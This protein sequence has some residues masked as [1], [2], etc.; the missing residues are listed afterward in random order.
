MYNDQALNSKLDSRKQDTLHDSPLTTNTAGP[1]G[2][3][4]NTYFSICDWACEDRAYPHIKIGVF[5]ELHLAITF[6]QI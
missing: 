4:Y 1:T 6:T 2:T 3:C 5:F